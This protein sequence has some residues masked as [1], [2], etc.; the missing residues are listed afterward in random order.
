M[1]ADISDL[2][3]PKFLGSFPLVLP[4]GRQVRCHDLEF[5]DTETRMYCAGSI[6][7][8]ENRKDLSGPTIWDVSKLSS[9]QIARE[10]RNPSWPVIGFVGESEVKGQGDHHAPRAVINGKLYMVAANELR[11]N[12]FPQLFDISDE[13]V[14]RP[15]SEFRLESND[16]ALADASWAKANAAGGYGLHYNSVVDSAWG[17]VALGM[18]SFMGSGARI[19]DLRD[20]LKPREIAYYHPG[21]PPPRAPRAGPGSGGPPTGAGASDQCVTQEFFIPETG[22]IWFSCQSGGLYIAE[23][24]PAVKAYLGVH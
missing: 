7:T 9:G 2:S 10:R 6:P 19:V 14:L 22:H 16:R 15:V 5:N 1:V 11:P 8:P 12:A 18:F 4:G 20:P 13:K 23:L 17:K 21:A 3:V 24:S